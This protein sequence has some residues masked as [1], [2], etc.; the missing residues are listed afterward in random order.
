MN[1]DAENKYVT[2]EDE[3]KSNFEKAVRDF[4]NSNN[5]KR[6]AGFHVSSLVYEC[7]RKTFWDMK[8]PN[9]KEEMDIEGLYRTWMGTK[10][11]ETPITDKH[12]V[13]M[14]TK[15]HGYIL[16]G[17]ID[18]I[19]TTSQGSFLLDKK[20]VAK[21]PDKMYE[22]HRNQVMY[23]AVMLKDIKHMSIDGIG[24]IYFSVGSNYNRDLGGYDDRIKVYVEKV[25]DD[26]LEEYRKKLYTFIDEVSLYL[27]SD[28]IPER[29]VSWYCKYCTFKA[30]CDDYE[31]TR[32]V[33]DVIPEEEVDAVMETNKND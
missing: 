9:E 6:L 1:D 20:F 8:F 16:S 22:H 25:T 17:T 11:H 26:I 14:K 7:Q 23:Y 12:E 4:S 13:H 19:M 31:K 2:V 24:L 32:E 30:Q 3:I 27:K 29:R 5:A 15:K 21:L 18:E 28:I 10:L 33:E